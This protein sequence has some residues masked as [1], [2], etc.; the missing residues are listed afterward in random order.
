MFSHIILP[1]TSIAALQDT[2]DNCK[3]YHILAV[4]EYTD[5]K[6]LGDS[7]GRAQSKARAGGLAPQGGIEEHP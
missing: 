2:T 4:T 5:A 3:N 1:T 7:R 6:D